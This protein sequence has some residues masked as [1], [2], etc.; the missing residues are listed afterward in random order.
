MNLQVKRYAIPAGTT[1]TVMIPSGSSVLSIDAVSGDPFLR[2]IIDADQGVM[3]NANLT[4]A[5]LGSTLGSSP[6]IWVGSFEK[7]GVSYD[8]F[9][10]NS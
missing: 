1:P 7:L 3:V 6:G 5:V 2:A 8:V 9:K 4:V 10:A